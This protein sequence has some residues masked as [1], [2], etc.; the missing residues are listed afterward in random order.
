[1]PT[2]NRLFD[3][4]KKVI[5]ENE[6]NVLIAEDFAETIYSLIEETANEYYNTM[7]VNKEEF[8]TTARFNHWASKH[9]KK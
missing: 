7:K 3:E 8:G 1:M 4:I 6:Y 9:F 2:E 5:E